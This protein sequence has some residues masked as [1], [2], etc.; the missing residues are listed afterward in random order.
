MSGH[1]ATI[2]STQNNDEVEQ[3]LV[4]HG[5]KDET[6]LV[7]E[8]A[9]AFAEGSIVEIDRA[10]VRVYSHVVEHPSEAA[11]TV[12]EEFVNVERHFAH[13]TVRRTEV[14]GPESDELPTDAAKPTSYSTEKAEYR[15][16]RHLVE[17]TIS[18]FGDER[19]ASLWL[20][21]P[22]QEMQ[23]KVPMQVAQSVGYSRAELENIFEPIFLRIEHGI[24]S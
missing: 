14:E 20:S 17:R 19:K 13:D 15:S 7:S 12:R 2:A 5:K 22:S 1:R 21:T 3:D 4:S 16:Y 18:V 24:Y 11:M 10:G 8:T 23:G 6:V 9:I